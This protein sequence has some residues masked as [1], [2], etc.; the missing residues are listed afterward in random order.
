M[1][2]PEVRIDG[3]RYVPVSQAHVDA[4]KIIDTLVKQWGGDGWQR[5]YADAPNYLRVVVS[6]TFEEG[7]G[8]S[9]TDFVGRLI[10]DG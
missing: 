7:E 2:E 9:V 4:D 6:D 1:A 8:E 3:V 10:S 5:L